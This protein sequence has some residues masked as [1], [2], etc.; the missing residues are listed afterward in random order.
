MLP[1]QR[2]AFRSVPA[3]TSLRMSAVPPLPQASVSGD[4]PYSSAVFTFRARRQ[5][6]LRRR[7]VIEATARKHAAPS[8]RATLTS[9]RA[10]IRV[11]SSA[12]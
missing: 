2:A 10:W 4:S 3:S 11:D 9:A 5:R 6:H 7:R 12:R 8:G 1:S